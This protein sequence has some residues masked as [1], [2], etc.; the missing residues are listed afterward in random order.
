MQNRILKR[1]LAGL[2]FA[3]PLLLANGGLAQTILHYEL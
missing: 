1:A 2:A 3:A